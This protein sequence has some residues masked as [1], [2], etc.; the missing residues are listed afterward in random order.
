MLVAVPEAVL[1]VMLEMT[2]EVE[3][4]LEIEVE[5][6]EEATEELLAGVVPLVQ[7]AAPTNALQVPPKMPAL[8][9]SS[10]NWPAVTLSLA[11]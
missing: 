4:E 10:V 5:V 2:L 1:E 11:L 3:L 6:V 7:A 8:L 9:K